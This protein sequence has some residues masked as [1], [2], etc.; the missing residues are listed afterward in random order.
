MAKSVDT[1]LSEPMFTVSLAISA[2]A[3]VKQFGKMVEQGRNLNLAQPNPFR[4]WSRRR[5]QSDSR[6]RTIPVTSA[7]NGPAGNAVSR[8]NS[9]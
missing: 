8:K 6:R 7:F 1:Y 4:E 5:R 3:G 2:E 9:T